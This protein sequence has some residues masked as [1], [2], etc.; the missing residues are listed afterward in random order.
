MF[1]LELQKRFDASG[2]N[3]KSLA[4]HPGGTK[5]DLQRHSRFWYSVMTII[6]MRADKGALSTLYAATE[7]TATGGMYV[8]PDGLME[9]W[10]YPAP[11]R[12]DP[13]ALDTGV[14]EQLWRFAEDAT[15]VAV[16]DGASRCSMLSES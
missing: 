5:T 11:A 9:V 3:V 12:I 7:P 1:A 15:G 16:D 8:G 10:G 13:A 4:A 2:R 6:G 14:R